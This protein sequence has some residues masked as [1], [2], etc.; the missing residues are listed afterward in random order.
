MQQILVLDEKNYTDDMPVFEK[1][2]VRAI[3]ERNGLFAMQKGNKG[4]Y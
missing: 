3:I 1:T 4:E 2:G